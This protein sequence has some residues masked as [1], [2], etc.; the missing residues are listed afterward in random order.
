M[1]NL[2]L[3]SAAVIA[4]F[5]TVSGEA[6]ADYWATLNINYGYVDGDLWAHDFTVTRDSSI[7]TAN[8][9]ALTVNDNEENIK[10]RVKGPLVN[11]NVNQDAH[12]RNSQGVDVTIDDMKNTTGGQIALAGAAAGLAGFAVAGAAA[13]NLGIVEQDNDVRVYDDDRNRQFAGNLSIIH[14]QDPFGGLLDCGCS[15][16]DFYTA[17]INKGNVSGDI[18]AGDFTISRGSSLTAANVGAATINSSVNNMS[19]K[20]GGRHRR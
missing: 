2:L 20:V 9:G 19:V 16:D 14:V 3:A 10:V 17:N 11:I 13:G 15:S 8:I 7:G 6:K 5:A 18:H 1:R 12:N 4:T